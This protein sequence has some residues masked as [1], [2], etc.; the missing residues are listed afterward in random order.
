MIRPHLR[1]CPGCSR[2]IRVA[3]ESC[4]FC[5]IL[6]GAPFRASPAPIPPSRRL[7]RAALVAFGAGATVLTPA[8]AVDCSSEDVGSTN[9]PYGQGPPFD[10]A[11]PEDSGFAAPDVLVV[12]IDASDGSIADGAGE[13]SESGD[14]EGGD[15]SVADTGADAGTGG[16]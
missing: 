11:E 14:V 12:S 8:L 7:S 4:P 15:S 5:G 3:E 9:A 13:T 6:L 16:D 2:H 10:A 1:A